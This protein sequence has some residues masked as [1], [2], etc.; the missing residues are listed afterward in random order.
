M[1]QNSPFPLSTPLIM[2]L[3]LPLLLLIHFGFQANHSTNHPS[4]LGAFSECVL[5]HSSSLPTTLSQPIESISSQSCPI[6]LATPSTLVPQPL[7]VVT[8]P[9]APLQEP[10]E[11]IPSQSCPIPDSTSPFATTLTQPTTLNHHPMQTKTKSGI[12]K[13]NSK[14]CYKAVLDYNYTEP[15]TYK[16]ASKYPKW[17]KA[18]DVEFQAL[19]R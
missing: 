8:L 17:C 18:M 14:L 9:N 1:S 6:P 7:S 10:P 19:Q 15:P 2:L 4:L 13:P 16:G 12:T 11:S 3:L 5:P